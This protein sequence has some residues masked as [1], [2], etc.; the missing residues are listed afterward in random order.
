MEIPSKGFIKTD[1]K[2]PEIGLKQKAE[3]IRKGNEALNN[4]N[5]KLAKKIFITTN[6]SDGL[7]RLGDYYYKNND[8]IEAMKMYI[9]ANDE[10]KKSWF[11]KNVAD[12]IRGW[13]NE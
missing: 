8:F 13:L 9:M 2:K 11:F 10:H 7:S 3:L 1:Y 5:I 6:Y 12:L 4:E